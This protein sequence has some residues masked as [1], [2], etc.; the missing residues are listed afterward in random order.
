MTNRFIELMCGDRL[1]RAGTPQAE[2]AAAESP[3][4]R[5]SLLRYG[6]VSVEIDWSGRDS[7]R[8]ATMF[9][10]LLVPIVLL[11]AYTSPASTG[12]AAFAY[13]AEKYGLEIGFIAGA[14]AAGI[15]LA[16]LAGT[17]LHDSWVHNRISAFD[18]GPHG[19]Y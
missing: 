6:E 14:A 5:E 3:Y 7:V 19:G 15:S 10:R 12:G 16:V 13:F 17:V 1:L 18:H 11:T 9:E 4:L 8:A 2:K